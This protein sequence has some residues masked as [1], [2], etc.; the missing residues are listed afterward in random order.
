MA[1]PA[2]PL[3]TNLTL[4]A[5]LW[6]AAALPVLLVALVVLGWF[7]GFST[8]QQLAQLEAQVY[9]LSLQLEA[10]KSRS[11]AYSIEALQLQQSLGV[12]ETEI[13]RLR[14]KIGLPRIR[15]VP[16]PSQPDPIPGSVGAPRGAG[17]PIDLGSLLLSLRSQVSIFAAEL[18]A[19]ALAL[20]NPPPPDPPPGRALRHPMPFVAKHTPP[21]PTQSIPA[22]PPLRAEASLTSGFGYRIDPFGGRIYEFHDGVDFAAPLGTP[23]YATAAGT[24]SEMGWNPIYGLMVLI[25]HGN[26]LHTLYGHL[27]TSLV[28]KAQQV[29]Q[30][31]LIGTVGS[32][33]RATGPHLHYA[34]YRYGL[35]VDPL[36]FI[37]RSP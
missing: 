17:E 4:T 26:G 37:E 20:N 9:K 34:I 14:A 25:D 21:N 1:R 19:T 11:E 10:E 6:L 16:E 36:P 15:L 24:V 27:S 28:E 18:E 5:P 30:G 8:R 31:H 35:A 7:R 22:G 33:G 2:H 29:A 3:A 13:N 32:T 23:V 12:L